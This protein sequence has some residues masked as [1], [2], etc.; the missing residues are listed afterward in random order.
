MLYVIL[1]FCGMLVAMVIGVIWIHEQSYNVPDIPPHPMEQRVTDIKNRI[2]AMQMKFKSPT[3]KEIEK[4][5]T[6]ITRKTELDDM[7][8]KLMP[9]SVS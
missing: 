2:E 4:Q 7:R 9:K 8:R 1:F 5:S 6:Q 3:L